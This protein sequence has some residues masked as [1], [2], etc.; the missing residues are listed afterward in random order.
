MKIFWDVDTQLDFMN[1]DGAL[2]VPDVS[3]IRNNLGKLAQYAKNNSIKI[4]KTGDFH[5]ENDEKISNNP[6]I[7][8]TFPKHC[9]KGTI[10]A[11]F[12]TDACCGRPCVIV[13]PGDLAI[14][15]KDFK[16]DLIII[17][18]NKFD[19]FEGNHWTEGVLNF[20][21]PKK[22]AV[23]YVY[24]V[25]L[26]VSVDYA[27]MENLKLGRKVYAIL[28]CMKGLSHLDDTEISTHA[29]IT[30]WEKSGVGFIMT[31]DVLKGDFD[32]FSLNHIYNCPEC[33]GQH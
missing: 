18:K 16:R 20:I 8:N 3:E 14:C 26:N 27:I 21:D 6:D 30:K 5:T 9:M 22:E 15:S 29:T 28:D 31:E 12:I 23:I 2:S 32:G 1:K 7:I 24:G 25:A 17:R 4:I 19:I 13:M 11:S 10:G 33:G